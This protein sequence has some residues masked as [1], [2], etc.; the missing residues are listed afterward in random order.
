MSADPDH[1]H[2]PH[3]T[4]G[5]MLVVCILTMGIEASQSLQK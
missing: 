4:Q 1:G 3:P 5:A 2:T